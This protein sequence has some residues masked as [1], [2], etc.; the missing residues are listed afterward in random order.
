MLW[1]RGDYSRT[2]EL[3]TS[4]GSR[5][6]RKIPPLASNTLPILRTWV[7]LVPVV[8]D[9]QWHVF[10]S[11]D[12]LVGF[13][14]GREEPSQESEAPYHTRTLLEIKIFTCSTL[15]MRTKYR[16]GGFQS[17]LCLCLPLHVCQYVGFCPS[18][19]VDVC[20]CWSLSRSVS[21][22]LFLLF[23]SPLGWSPT[24]ILKRRAVKGHIA[25]RL[26]FYPPPHA[27]IPRKPYTLKP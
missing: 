26:F 11:G 7:P 21:C 9:R 8:L 17:S 16:Q 14:G 24:N 2:Q 27:P 12:D 15:T 23:L 6:D 3:N 22:Y 4:H 10:P 13:T 19:T 18:L 20:V 1:G 25:V 5:R